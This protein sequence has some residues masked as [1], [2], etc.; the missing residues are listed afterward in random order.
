MVL[1]TAFGWSNGATVVAS[2]LLAFAVRVRAHEP[3]A[4]ALRHAAAARRAARLRIDTL[5]IATMEIVDTLIVL[6]IPGALDAGL[7]DPLFWGSLVTALALAGAAAYPVNRR[8]MARGKGHAVAH[9]H[10]HA[11]P[12]PSGTTRSPRSGMP[13]R[14]S[15]IAWGTRIRCRSR[16]RSPSTR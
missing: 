13:S 2:I 16:S 4:G 12:G 8:L 10:A 14:R 5:S 3:A 15:A 11:P 6:L 9:G 7:A 1:G